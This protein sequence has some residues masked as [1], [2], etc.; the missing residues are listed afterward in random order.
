MKP[1]HLLNHGVSWSGNS[2]ITLYVPLIL[3]LG[4][5]SFSPGF[6]LPWIVTRVNG[7]RCYINFPTPALFDYATTLVTHGLCVCGISW[8]RLQA[9]IHILF[10][11]YSPSSRVYTL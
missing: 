10:D 1:K 2:S 8:D 5:Y 3:A 7:L 9:E 4:I 6:E 11:N